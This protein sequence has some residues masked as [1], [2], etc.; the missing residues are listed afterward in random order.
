MACAFRE[1]QYGRM[2]AHTGLPE[3]RR[4]PWWRT[5]SRTQ[6]RPRPEHRR[7]PAGGN[8]RSERA[9]VAQAQSGNQAAREALV[10]AYMPLISAV[11]LAYRPVAAVHRDELTQ[12]GVVGLLRAL[13]RYEP[14]RG[15]PFWPYAAWWVRQAMQQVVSELSRPLV[16][17]DRALRQVARIRAA[18][19]QFE[20]R[21]RREATTAELA[22]IV[23]IPRGQ[24]ESLLN[25]ERAA[26]GIDE[27]AGAEGS[28]RPAVGDQLADPAAQEAYEHV[29]E[30]LLADQVPALLECLDQRERRVVCARFGLGRSEQTLREI[31]PDLGVSAERVRQI[32]RDSLDKL[33]VAATLQSPAASQPPDRRRRKGR[34]DA[35]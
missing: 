29:N 19:H 12:E 9:L 17:S 33:L 4:K 10:R 13:E 1:G 32:E 11:A 25:A 5:P 3:A 8:E 34:A 31:G 2:S 7:P 27:P 26:R 14:D 24:V 22:A 15:V 28:D 30:Q 18:Q 6:G 35:R 20:Q 23:A 21:H 16:L